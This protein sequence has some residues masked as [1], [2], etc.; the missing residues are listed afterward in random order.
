MN[1]RVLAVI[2]TYNRAKYLK[3][4]LKS[5][6]NQTQDLYGILILDNNSSDNT[7]NMLKE[8]NFTK[9]NEFNTLHEVKNDVVKYYYYRNSENVG[10]SGGFNIAFKLAINLDVDYFWVMDDDV[11]PEN[12]CLEKLLS[13]I[14]DDVSICIPNRSDNN[15]TDRAIISINLNNPFKIKSAKKTYIDIKQQKYISVVD[16]PFE[17]PL[18]KKDIV[19]KVGFPND[20]YFILYDDTDYAMRCIKYTKI[21][22][23][24]N[25]ILHKQIIQK[26]NKNSVMDWKN[27]YDIRNSIIFDKKYGKNI[28]VKNVRPI[29]LWI[30]LTIRALI[31]RKFYNL[32]I[33]NR[34]FRD[35][36]KGVIG[37]T[38]EPGS[39]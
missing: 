2:V 9:R 8:M 29:V 35:G 7:Y 11:L 5:L 12:N 39:I 17:G 21:Y 26:K 36:I 6:N 23:I 3:S 31:L 32:K 27:Y 1:K 14:T 19:N 20:K 13:N 16:M 38:V 33:I 28:L 34:G 25:A 15:Y 22:M 37:K 24:P 10:G 4:L 18:I 30:D